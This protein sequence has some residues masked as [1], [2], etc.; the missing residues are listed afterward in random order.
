M[1]GANKVIAF[2]GALSKGK[3]S[4]RQRPV[5]NVDGVFGDDLRESF[6]V[7][8]SVVA[9]SSGPLLLEPFPLHAK[10]AKMTSAQASSVDNPSRIFM[11][12]R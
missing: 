12:Q 8:V 9:G 6:R 5:F 10:S 1:T 7:V 3:C 2:H 11:K 4:V